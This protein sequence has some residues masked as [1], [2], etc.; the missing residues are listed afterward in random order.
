MVSP[1]KHVA[2]LVL[3][4]EMKSCAHRGNA[5]ASSV[6]AGWVRGCAFEPVEPGSRRPSCPA[7]RAAARS[8]VPLAGSTGGENRDPSTGLTDVRWTSVADVGGIRAGDDG[9]SV[10]FSCVA[11]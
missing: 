10:P 9:P 11:N 6:G 5:S 4:W 3:P 1:M 7:H 2:L 8:G